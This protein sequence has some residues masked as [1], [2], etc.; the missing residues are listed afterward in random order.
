[1]Y[2]AARL[3][4]MVGS[5]QISNLD[6]YLLCWLVSMFL[7][8]V[9]GLLLPLV[10]LGVEEAH[11]RK[12]FLALEQVGSPFIPTLMTTNIHALGLIVGLMP[13]VYQIIRLGII[14]LVPAI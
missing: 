14:Y 3:E 9:F 11:A 2:L 13:V 5:F 12:E 10:L 8:V 7:Q 4:R 6:S 1:M